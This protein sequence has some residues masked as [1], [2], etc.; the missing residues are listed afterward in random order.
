MGKE[1]ATHIQD[2][3]SPTQHK[4]KKKHAETNFNQNKN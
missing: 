2:M 3:Q 4:L 1:I